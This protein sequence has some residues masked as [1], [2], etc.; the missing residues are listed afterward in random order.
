[1]EKCETKLKAFLETPPDVIVL[2]S[3]DSSFTQSLLNDFSYTIIAFLTVPGLLGMSKRELC[4][5]FGGWMFVLMIN[6]EEK[7]QFLYTGHFL[8]SRSKKPEILEPV[9]VIL[10]FFLGC[11]LSVSDWD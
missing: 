2:R 5:V 3:K 10:L 6:L 11:L 8:Y 7:N 1:M 4:C 9:P